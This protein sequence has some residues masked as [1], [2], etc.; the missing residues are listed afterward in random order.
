MAIRRYGNAEF[1]IDMV[2]R[3]YSVHKYRVKRISGDTQPS[4]ETLID[5]C[6]YGNFGGEVIQQPDGSWI[7]KV[8]VD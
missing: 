6:D 8:Y 3:G 1:D 4:K 5:L 7:V 2:D